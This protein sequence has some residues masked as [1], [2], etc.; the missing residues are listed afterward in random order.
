MLSLF[1]LLLCSLYPVFFLPSFSLSLSFFVMLEK[2]FWKNSIRRRLRKDH[3]YHCDSNNDDPTNSSSSGDILTLRASVPK[4]SMVDLLILSSPP[5]FVPQFQPFITPSVDTETLMHYDTRGGI[6]TFEHKQ[7]ARSMTLDEYSWIMRELHQEERLPFL[8]STH[9]SKVVA[10]IINNNL[11][12]RRHSFKKMIGRPKMV[13]LL[14]PKTLL[15]SA[16]AHIPMSKPLPPP[17]HCLV[18]PSYDSVSEDMYHRLSR[19]I[20]MT[21]FPDECMHHNSPLRHVGMICHQCFTCMG[22]NESATASSLVA[23]VSS[24]SG[25]DNEPEDGD[26]DD[27]DDDDDGQPQSHQRRQERRTS[28]FTAP[29]TYFPALK[30]KR[31][32]QSSTVPSASPRRQQQQRQQHQHQ[33]E[34]RLCVDREKEEIIVVFGYGLQPVSFL[35]HDPHNSVSV[36]PWPEGGWVLEWAA[37]QWRQVEVSVATA[38]MRLCRTTPA[39]YRV[40]LVGSQ[41]GGALAALCA[42]SLVITGLLTRHVTLCVMDAPRTGSVEFIERLQKHKVETIRVVRLGNPHSHWPPRT[43]GL[44][45]LG[46]TTVLWLKN[47]AKMLKSKRCWDE[48][49]DELAKLYRIIKL[50]ETIVADV[51]RTARSHNNPSMGSSRSIHSSSRST[52]THTSS[53]DCQQHDDVFVSPTALL[54]DKNMPQLSFY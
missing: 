14:I 13:L 51:R 43:T 46:A 54:M 39:H 20:E 17:V 22:S 44:C 37:A 27:D 34:Y 52:S 9:S 1:S 12:D 6:V 32:P 29:T 10:V 28:A 45:H 38:L 26:D 36:V 48:I 24:L 4:H 21:A 53:N 15:L 47:Q 19:Y 25:T 30:V 42:S 49:E 31:R 18:P 7:M 5:R 2:N 16:A 50:D 3:Y 23:V 8:S 33:C 35:V 41:W 40:I 11:Q